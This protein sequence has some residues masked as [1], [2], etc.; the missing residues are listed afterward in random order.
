MS[1]LN[2]LLEGAIMLLGVFGPPVFL[3]TAW[4][5]RVKEKEQPSP[6]LRCLF[7]DIALVGATLDLVAIWAVPMFASS[8][9]KGHE[10]DGIVLW[11]KLVPTFFCFSILFLVIASLGK[12]KGK[13]F[14]IISC[15]CLVFSLVAID[16][17]R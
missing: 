16:A 4:F 5:R 2:G 1:G 8:T 11:T 3:G 12:G 17:M 13:I 10:W 15:V 14:T 7:R 9:A 6:R